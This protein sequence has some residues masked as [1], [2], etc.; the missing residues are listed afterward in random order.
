MPHQHPLH[1]Y[2]M[3][4]CKVNTKWHIKFRKNYGFRWIGTT[5]DLFLVIHIYPKIKSKNVQC[6]S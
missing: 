3:H 2:F 1:N 5:L 6:F 4:A